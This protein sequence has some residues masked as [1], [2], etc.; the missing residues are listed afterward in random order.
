[1]S[2]HAQSFLMSSFRISFVYMCTYIIWFPK[3]CVQTRI[4]LLLN[5]H[6]SRKCIMHSVTHVVALVDLI[7]RTTLYL[8]PREHKY[9]VL[10][11]AKLPNP[12]ILFMYH[13]SEDPESAPTIAIE[14]IFIRAMLSI[15]FH[16]SS[17]NVISSR[18]TL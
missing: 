13:H 7:N 12:N 8:I 4:L 14:S 1:M 10:K 2:A 18:V 3:R 17:V 15:M 6:I 11:K 9:Y 5:S 16:C